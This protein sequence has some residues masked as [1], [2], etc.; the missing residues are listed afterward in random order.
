MIRS[1]TIGEGKYT[2]RYDEATGHLKAERHG[3]PWRDLTGDGLLLATM[4]EIEELHAALA[5][6][7]SAIKDYCDGENEALGRLAA[8][9]LKFGRLKEAAWGVRH[10]VPHPDDEQNWAGQIREF[11]RTLVDLGPEGLK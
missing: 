11:N 1:V 4:Q 9:D 10:L 5:L 3:E 6:Q 8:L 2:L 7:R